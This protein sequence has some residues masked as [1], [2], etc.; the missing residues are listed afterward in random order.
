MRWGFDAYT[1]NT[2][3]GGSA[4]ER[5]VT[6]LLGDVS[7]AQFDYGMGEYE[8]SD[9]QLEKFSLREVADVLATIIDR[10]SA[11]D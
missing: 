9:E 3:K 6:V 2:G 10:E 4:R 5:V 11:R 7:I 1:V 8:M